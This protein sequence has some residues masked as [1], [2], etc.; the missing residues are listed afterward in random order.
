MNKEDV[1]DT[2]INPLMAEIIKIC[3]ENKIAMLASFAI[4]TEENPSGPYL[5]SLP[6]LQLC[7]GLQG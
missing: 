1:Y 6:G 4:P 2:Q 7:E 3:Q 5:Q